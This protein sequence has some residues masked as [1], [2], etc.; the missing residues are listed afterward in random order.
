MIGFHLYEREC[1]RDGTWQALTDELIYRNPQAFSPGSARAADK[2]EWVTGCMFALRGKQTGN[3]W[4]S[5]SGEIAC[6]GLSCQ[7]GSICHV[8]KRTGSC[9]FLSEIIIKV[10]TRSKSEV[11]L[12][13]HMEF[14][15]VAL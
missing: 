8:Q 12:S 5:H 13:G 9:L 2:L 7:A 1:V 14:T 10:T 3:G 4:R 11:N 15:S 6:Y